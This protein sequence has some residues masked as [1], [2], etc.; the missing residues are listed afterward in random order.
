[1]SSMDP[2]STWLSE[3]LDRMESIEAKILKAAKAAPVK[4]RRKVIVDE[5]APHKLTETEIRAF[6]RLARKGKSK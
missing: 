2:G 3:E 1:M 4:L 6:M 5:A